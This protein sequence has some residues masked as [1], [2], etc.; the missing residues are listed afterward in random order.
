MT[1]KDI[2]DMATWFLSCLAEFG[3]VRN[4][5]EVWN[6]TLLGHITRPFLGLEV[7]TEVYIRMNKKD[8]GL[9]HVYHRPGTLEKDPDYPEEDDPED[10]EDEDEEPV[11]CPEP[12]EE[13][14]SA[15]W[16]NPETKKFDFRVGDMAK[17]CKRV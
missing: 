12:S 6:G 1:A 10:E 13:D 16:E 4:D 15:W 8:A 14:D 17:I 3:P 7:G 9:Y 2:Q 5:D 11:A